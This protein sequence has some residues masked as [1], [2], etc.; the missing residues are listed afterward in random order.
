MGMRRTYVY[1]MIC[2]LL[3]RLEEE[4]S[5]FML[6]GVCEN[7][8]HRTK[9]CMCVPPAPPSSMLARYVFVGSANVCEINAHLFEYA[10][11]RAGNAPP[12]LKFGARGCS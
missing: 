12:T 4:N 9:C 5:V 1:C 7:N 6:T 3:Q 10:S 11:D 8:A 2:V